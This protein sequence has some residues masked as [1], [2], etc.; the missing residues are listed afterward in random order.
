MFGFH[1]PETLAAWMEADLK[2]P[3]SGLRSRLRI[4]PPLPRDGLWEHQHRVIANLEQ[5]LARNQPRALIHMTWKPAA[6][7]FVPVGSTVLRQFRY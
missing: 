5:S 7:F 6:Q 4:M 3:G 1:R 2:S